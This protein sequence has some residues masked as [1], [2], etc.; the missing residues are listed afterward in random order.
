MK[1][2]DDVKAILMKDADGVALYDVVSN[3][4]LQERNKG[5]GLVTEVQ[6][7]LD[8][9]FS[10]LKAIGF[11]PAAGDSD[12]FVSDIKGKLESVDKSKEKLSDSEKRLQ[13]FE[14][15]IKTLTENLSKS[16]EKAT[17][18][19]TA[20][21]GGIMKDALITKLSGKLHGAEAHVK[22]II[23]DGL[24]SLADDNKT[25][26]WKKGNETIELDK[27]LSEYQEANKRDI[28]NDQRPGSG[29]GNPGG[30]DTSRKVMPMGEFEKLSPV[31]RMK[32]MKEGG[33]LTD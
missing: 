22:A 1:T 11:D 18:F 32:Y 29:T 3:A 8:R 20:Y 26:L 19:E 24:V 27:G 21:K 16:T 2:L 25:V 12:T 9:A 4:I 13:S 31:D 5:K 30:G 23:A 10:T 33:D 15:S 6:T 14:S 28:I 7:K 17:R